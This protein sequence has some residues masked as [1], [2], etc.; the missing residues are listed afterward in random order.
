MTWLASPKLSNTLETK[1]DKNW[2]VKE[3]R[4]LRK[5][6]HY[7]DLSAP[8]LEEEIVTLV[9][10]NVKIVETLLQSWIKEMR[11]FVSFCRN[12]RYLAE[13]FPDWNFRYHTKA[14]TKSNSL[15]KGTNKKSNEID[16]KIKLLE[17][18]LN[19]LRKGCNFKNQLKNL[20][21][22]N[23]LKTD[24]VSPSKKNDIT[25]EY[26]FPPK[27]TKLPSESFL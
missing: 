15:E 14:G 5:K 8:D 17:K 27:F 25:D 18:Q 20:L 4:L 12:L 10:S 21:L 6:D 3:F 19:F 24:I 7:K 11:K 22:E 23:F 13:P 9:S 26:Y 2:K 1:I 16:E